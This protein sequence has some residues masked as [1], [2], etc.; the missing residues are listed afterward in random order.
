MVEVYW[1]INAFV[2]VGV[3]DDGVGFY[4][5]V[6]VGGVFV[7]EDEEVDAPAFGEVFELLG[8]VASAPGHEVGGAD[9]GFVVLL[10]KIAGE[11][12]G[13]ETVHHAWAWEGMGA[14]DVALG[15]VGTQG[16]GHGKDELFDG[17]ADDLGCVAEVLIEA[18]VEGFDATDAVFDDEGVD[19]LGKLVVGE[20]EVDELWV[21]GFE[22]GDS[23]EALVGGVD[24]RGVAWERWFHVGMDDFVEGEVFG[25]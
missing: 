14:E 18:C 2:V 6:A 3:E 7:A 8:V 13:V 22:F 5:G 19:G 4:E 12:G 11:D 15:T 16:D 9:S 20:K 25:F 24:W 10:G 1:K 21:L 23:G 17:V